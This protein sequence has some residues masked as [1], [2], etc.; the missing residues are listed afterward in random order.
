[1]VSRCFVTFRAEELHYGAVNKK[2]TEAVGSLRDI[3]E[4]VADAS[5]ATTQRY[6]HCWRQRG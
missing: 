6:I 3:Q 4:F 2:I 5:L 1:L